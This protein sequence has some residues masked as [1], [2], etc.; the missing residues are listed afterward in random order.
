MM[1]LRTWALAAAVTLTG[2]AGLE[3]D[4]VGAVLEQALAEGVAAATVA[5]A[6]EDSGTD[7]W[8]VGGLAGL[9]AVLSAAVLRWRQ[10]LSETAALKVV[11]NGKAKPPT[12][13][14]GTNGA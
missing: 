13:A 3:A 6:D 8:Q 11:A 1:I 7:P 9:A 5:A 14:G 2:C 12:A 4:E 10:A